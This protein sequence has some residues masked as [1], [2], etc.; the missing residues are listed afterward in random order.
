MGRIKAGSFCR[1]ACTLLTRSQ[2]DVRAAEERWRLLPAFFKV[3]GLVRHHIESFNFFLSTELQKIMEANSRVICDVEP[4]FFLMYTAIR[5]G[6]P[7]VEED[8]ITNDITPQACRLRD[9]TYAAPLYVDLQYVRG[10]AVVHRKSE[11]L[12]LLAFQRSS[13]TPPSQMW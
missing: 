3:R 4:S 11:L 1:P 2:A 5:V 8:L 7:S 6:S 9:I 10:R 12:F 13:N